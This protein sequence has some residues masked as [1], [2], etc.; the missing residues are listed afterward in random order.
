MIAATK[1][2][3][4]V[5]AGKPR[6][7]NRRVPIEI[8]EVQSPQE[9]DQISEPKSEDDC[10]VEGC[11]R[12]GFTRGCCEPCYQTA[13]KYVKLGRTTWKR[14]EELGL[15]RAP[16]NNGKKFGPMGIAIEKA[17]GSLPRTQ[18]PN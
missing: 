13:Q 10:I 9:I 6:L 3:Q 1:R 2:A 15:V 18:K 5:T 14:L 12:R 16:R 17:L 7:K 11:T 8:P 4:K